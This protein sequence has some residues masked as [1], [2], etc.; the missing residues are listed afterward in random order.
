[1][2]EQTALY[3]QGREEI[4]AVNALRRLAGMPPIQM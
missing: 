1:M 3:A 4:A 2:E